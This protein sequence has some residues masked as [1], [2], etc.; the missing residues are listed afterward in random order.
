MGYVGQLAGPAM[1]GFIA[2]HYSLAAALTLVALLLCIVA[3][4][5]SFR[6]EKTI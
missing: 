6:K 3:L 5:Y 1:L 2:F 4:G